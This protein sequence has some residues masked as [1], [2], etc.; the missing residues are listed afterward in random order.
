MTHCSAFPGRG[1]SAAGAT[2]G[3]VGERGFLARLLP[4][5][6]PRPDVLVGAGD[7]CAVCAAPEPGLDLVFKSDPVREGA[8]FAPGEDMA[9]VGRKALGRVLSDFASMGAE[10]RWALVDFCAPAGFS[11]SAAEALYGGIDSMARRHGVA[12]V[13]GDTSR[14]GALELHVFA[15]GVV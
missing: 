14:G 3:D 10:P 12:V 5:L 2:L 13:G 7:D 15:A 11:V 4:M 1:G 8:H 9:R 6:A